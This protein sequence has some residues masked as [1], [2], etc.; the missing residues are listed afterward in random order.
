MTNHLMIRRLFVL[1]IF[2]I[3]LQTPSLAT[4]RV[5]FDQFMAGTHLALSKNSLQDKS[6]EFSAK[7]VLAGTVSKYIKHLLIN[8]EDVP[9][10]GRWFSTEVMLKPGKNAYKIVC[11]NKN[12]QVLDAGFVRTLVKARFLDV[13]DNHWT[14]AAVEDLATLGVMSSTHEALLF[15]SQV[16]SLA[17]LS[18]SLYNSLGY[19]VDEKFRRLPKDQQAL[20][21][22]A[23]VG[24]LDGIP[25]I[26]QMNPQQVLTWGQALVMVMNSEGLLKNAVSKLPKDTREIPQRAL[27]LA[28]QYA[29]LPAAVA[30]DIHL[31][32]A[33]GK[34][35]LSYLLAKTV[36]YQQA[37]ATLYDWD[38]YLSKDDLVFY[39]TIEAGKKALETEDL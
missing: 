10:Y 19:D 28:V 13:P 23:S 20:S 24:I 16:V 5:A 35:E 34:A 8:G 3:L 39:K 12:R 11:L 32:A 6:V 29:Y 36:R 38:S 14:T 18:Q 17:S 25:T 4:D 33:I 37:I 27:K 15:P 31:D 1:L 2:G 7:Q 9:L 30:P 26:E 21:A 22:A